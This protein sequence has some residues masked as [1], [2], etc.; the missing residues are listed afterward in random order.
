[1]VTEEP[2]TEVI[3]KVPFFAADDDESPNEPAA[4]VAPV[5]SAAILATHQTEEPTAE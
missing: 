2:S 3:L 1:M 5:E 4:I